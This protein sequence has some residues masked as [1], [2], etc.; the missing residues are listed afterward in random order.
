MKVV[1]NSGSASVSSLWIFLMV[2]VIGL[3]LRFR[4]SMISVLW[5]S[6][7]SSVSNAIL[8]ALADGD[9]VV[10]RFFTDLVISGSLR[11]SRWLMLPSYW[12]EEPR[13]K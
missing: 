11:R 4:C 12:M 13:M 9:N 1:S 7:L 3:K 8:V 5:M 2:S 6:D 10:I